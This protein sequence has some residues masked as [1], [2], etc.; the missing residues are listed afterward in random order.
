VI[1][2]LI[3]IVDDDESVRDSTGTLLRSAGYKIAKFESGEHF[4]E[5]DKVSET[6]C[7]ILDI[8]MPGMDGLEL[9]R[10]L[11][12]FNAGVPVI[13][14]TADDNEHHRKRAFEAGAS[15]FF[16][17]PFPAAEFL[18]AVRTAVG[19]LTRS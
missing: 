16:Q 9:Q 5:S 8:R 13:F 1:G 10:R 3:S 17:K 15:D 7:L 2:I 11:N 19:G 12:V 4:L 6:G 14:S 18:T